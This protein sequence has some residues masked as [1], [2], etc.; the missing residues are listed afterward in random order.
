MYGAQLRHDITRK[1]YAIFMSQPSRRFVVAVSLA[2]Q[3]FRLHVFD[4]SGVIHSLG[5]NLHRSPDLF[6][7][8]MYALAFGSPDKLGFDTTFIDPA[9]FPSLLYRPRSTPAVQ[10]SW[11]IYIRENVYAILRH[12]YA[13][14]LI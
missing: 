3:E 9:V 6:A 7:R 13:S 8:L 2:R 1:A 11:T 14:H 10:V 5:H 12:L 4:R